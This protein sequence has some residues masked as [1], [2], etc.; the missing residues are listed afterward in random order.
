MIK[1]TI[2]KILKSFDN[3]P[4]EYKNALYRILISLVDGIKALDELKVDKEDGKELSS[5]DFTDELK[6]KLDNIEP[7]ATVQ[8]PSDW[9]ATSGVT[10]ILNKPDLS[11]YPDSAEWNKTDKKIYFKHQGVVLNPFTIDGTDFIKDGM[12]DEVK[13]ENNKLVIIFNTDSG[14]ERIEIPL[15]KIFNPD[16]YY[17]KDKTDEL[18]VK[19]VNGKDLSTEDFTTELKEKLENIDIEGITD[20]EIDEL[21]NE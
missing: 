11:V 16:N 15:S 1:A 19:K 5:N 18:F 8:V 13:I 2:N 4:K 12:I 20:E 3:L 17:T 14:K 7:G 6:D 21:I 9:E 10:R